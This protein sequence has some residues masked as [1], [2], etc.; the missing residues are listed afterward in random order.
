MSAEKYTLYRS[1]EVTP[2]RVYRVWKQGDGFIS[3][4][5]SR[6]KNINGLNLTRKNIIVGGTNNIYF[7]LP[8]SEYDI[9][10]LTEEEV[11]HMPEVPA[12]IDGFKEDDYKRYY[13]NQINGY[14]IT[15][16]QLQ[17]LEEKIKER[18][19]ALL[20]SENDTKVLYWQN[21]EAIKQMLEENNKLVTELKATNVVIA[22]FIDNVLGIKS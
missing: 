10:P 9:P 20:K 1:A 8:S 14:P 19:N 2:I 12:S 15:L 16:D 6:T 3:P 13:I 17:N 11:D 22:K 18:E 7:Y 4:D 21:Q 5:V